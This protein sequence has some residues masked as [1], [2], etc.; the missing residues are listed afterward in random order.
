[1]PLDEPTM[2]RLLAER[3]MTRE[4]AERKLLD[5]YNKL[6]AAKFQNELPEN[7]IV[8]ISLIT[9]G[10]R[11]SFKMYKLNG[12]SIHFS[13]FCEPER[14]RRTMIHEMCH[15]YDDTHGE[16]FHAKLREVAADETWLTDE[17]EECKQWVIQDRIRSEWFTLARS[18]TEQNPTMTWVEGRKR[19][20][21]ALRC[22]VRDVT[23]V[24]YD[25]KE[26]WNRY[27]STK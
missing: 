15:F 3:G 9:G 6:N 25:F 21:Q 19:V 27:L 8:A 1:M 5:L 22:K 13:P 11:A 4:Q 12:V 23:N 10:P 2:T 14:Y 17:L 7:P 16:T 26:T 18:L 24:A 20:A